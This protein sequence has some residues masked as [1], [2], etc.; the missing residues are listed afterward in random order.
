MGYPTPDGFHLA[1]SSKWSW[2][3]R[4]GKRPTTCLQ[5]HR[6][7]ELFPVA[8]DGCLL[9]AKY[10][11]IPRNV[12]LL[13]NGSMKCHEKWTVLPRIEPEVPITELFTQ[14]RIEFQE[15]LAKWASETKESLHSRLD[16]FQKIEVEPTLH[17]W[18]FGM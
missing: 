13:S 15:L 14:D 17:R 2:W 10:V 11:A 9:P 8:R 18:E 5:A 1:M 4:W 7:D 16:V 3:P 6:D 12:S